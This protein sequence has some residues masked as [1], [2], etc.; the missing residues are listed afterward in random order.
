MTWTWI[1]AFLCLTGSA[2]ILFS[3]RARVET[4]ARCFSALTKLHGS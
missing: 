1:W 4:L 3:L 2:P